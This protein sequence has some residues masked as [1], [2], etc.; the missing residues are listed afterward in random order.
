MNFN[1]HPTSSPNV[2]VQR[3]MLQV[4][5]LVARHRRS[6]LRWLIGPVILVQVAIATVAAL[7]GEAVHVALPNGKPS[8][9]SRRRQ[10]RRHRLVD[11]PR[12]SAVRAVVADRR[13]H[14]ASPSWSPSISTADWA[15][16]LQPG[17]GAFA[18]ISLVPG[19][20][21]AMAGESP[22]QAGFG[23]QLALDFGSRR[24]STRSA[25]Q[26]RS[27]ALETALKL[28]EGGDR[29]SRCTPAPSAIAGNG[30]EWSAVPTCRRPL[31]VAAQRRHPVA[32]RSL[33]LLPAP[34]C[35]LARL[36]WLWNPAQFANPLF[37][38]FS[39]GSMLGAF[40]IV[41][42]PVSGCTTPKGKTDLSV[43]AGVLAYIIRVFGGY[44]TA[45]PSPSC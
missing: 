21:V 4:L 30:L 36:L 3:V 41:T 17:D 22:L 1:T 29:E 20:D 14:P 2:S 10:R 34:A 33:D 13:R 19:A 37:H 25:A 39:G 5:A 44:P 16:T 23:D 8:A 35:S 38:L 11:R 9:F 31:A 24:A 12:P 32:R 27:I 7:L 43:S 15:K 40:F 45:S 18:G 26:R 28:G 42:D 6:C